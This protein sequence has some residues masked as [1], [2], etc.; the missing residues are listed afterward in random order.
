MKSLGPFLS[1]FL[2]LSLFACNNSLDKGAQSALRTIPFRQAQA[3]VHAEL[4][5]NQEFVLLS[6]AENA[7]FSRVDK[8]LASNDR[9]YLFDHLDDAG[10]LVFDREG[11]F[12]QS[13]GEFGEG[14]N[15]LKTIDDFQVLENGDVLILDKIQKRIITYNSTGKFKAATSIPVNSGGFVK[16]EDTWFLAINFDHQNPDLIHNQKIG[17]FNSTFDPDSLYFHYPSNVPNAN[18]YYHAGILSQSQTSVVYHRPPNDTIAIFSSTGKLANQLV[19]DF[20]TNRLP[21]EVVFDFQLLDD[22]QPQDQVFRYLLTPVLPVSD[23]LFGMISGTDR[24]FWTFALHSKSMSLLVH[25]IDFDDF[26][27][28]KLILPS[29]NLDNKAI[30]SLIDPVTFRQDSNPEAYP[31]E[32]QNHLKKEGTVLLL[33]FLKR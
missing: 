7:L 3:M 13:I 14:P 18:V 20:E 16:Q 31:K 27:L 26:H 28:P 17:V 5:E 32:V 11:N 12:I 15:Q 25:K 23:Y 21:A 8:L 9:F 4:V 33:Q 2:F 29:A 19:I 30:V 6:T 24:T 1:P 10:V 22:F